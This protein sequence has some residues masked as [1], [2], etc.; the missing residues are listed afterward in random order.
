MT[1]TPVFLQDYG[2]TS[3]IKLEKQTH[4]FWLNSKC[5]HTPLYYSTHKGKCHCVL[6]FIEKHHNQIHSSREMDSLMRAT[7]LCKQ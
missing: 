3:E 1:S 6:F 5:H 4:N 2:N 7:L